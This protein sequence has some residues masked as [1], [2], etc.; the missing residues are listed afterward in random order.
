M[1]RPLRLL[2]L[3]LAALVLA[4]HA[5][6]PVKIRFLIYPSF[7]KRKGKAVHNTHLH[8]DMGVDETG[9]VTWDM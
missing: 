8:T 3:A 1:P 9:C 7:V 4:A 2:L 5:A 6:E